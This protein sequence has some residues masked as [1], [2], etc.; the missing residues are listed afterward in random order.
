MEWQTDWRRQKGFPNRMMNMRRRRKLDFRNRNRGFCPA[1]VDARRARW[2][3]ELHMSVFTSGVTEGSGACQFWYTNP[4][5]GFTGFLVNVSTYVS[6][7]EC[8]P[9]HSKLLYLTTPSFLKLIYNVYSALWYEYLRAA[10]RSKIVDWAHNE[11]FLSKHP[12]FRCRIRHNI[13]GLVMLSVR[14]SINFSVSWSGRD[15]CLVNSAFTLQRSEKTSQVRSVE[16]SHFNALMI[17]HFPGHENLTPRVL[18][19]CKRSD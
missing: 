16:W 13:V 17:L 18:C 2:M 8:S 1:Q 4:H 10:T 3:P 14:L 7:G 9:P 11:F 5:G 19:I 6:R 15:L 12:F